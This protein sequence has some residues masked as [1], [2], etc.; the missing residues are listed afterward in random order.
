[1]GRFG[2]IVRV[3]GC[4]QRWGVPWFPDCSRTTSYPPAL[5]TTQFPSK[6]TSTNYPVKMSVEN[7]SLYREI[8][9]AY[10][11]NELIEKLP[12]KGRVE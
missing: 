3:G 5:S 9:H 6:E 7:M 12:G 11:E 10:H 8:L 2:L 1:M 4:Q